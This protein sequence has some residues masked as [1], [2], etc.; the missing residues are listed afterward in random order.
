MVKTAF[1]CKDFN[2]IFNAAF[3]HLVKGQADE[4]QKL[5][6]SDMLL[7][8]ELARRPIVLGR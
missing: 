2:S 3:T 8:L 5:I 7:I 4:I 6:Q 1:F